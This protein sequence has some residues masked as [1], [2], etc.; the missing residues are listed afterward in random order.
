M[1]RSSDA[2]RSRL[3]RHSELRLI[4]PESG[5]CAAHPGQNIRQQKWADGRN[6]TH[7]ESSAE[8]LAQ[9]PRGFHEVFAFAKYSSCPLDN[10]VPQRGQYDTALGAVAREA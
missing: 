4:K 1:R 5:I 8:R 7:A 6:H 9:R 10:F 2:R 3:R